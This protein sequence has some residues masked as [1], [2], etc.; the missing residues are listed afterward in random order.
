MAVTFFKFD[1][2]NKKIF[3]Q[4]R[5]ELHKNGI[6]GTAYFVMAL[7][8]YVNGPLREDIFTHTNFYCIVFVLGY[9]LKKEADS[10]LK[11]FN[12]VCSDNQV[13]FPSL[14]GYINNYD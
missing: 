8:M 1:K 2:I 12:K 5:N 6:N 3:R 7:N 13:C 9:R 14:S 11:K 4:K 10:K